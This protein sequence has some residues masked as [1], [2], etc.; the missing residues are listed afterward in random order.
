VSSSLVDLAEYQATLSENEKISADQ[1]QR[2]SNER[3]ASYAWRL[4]GET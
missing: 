3:A 4:A 1:R 2:I